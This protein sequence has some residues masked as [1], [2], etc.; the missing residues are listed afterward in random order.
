MRYEVNLA[1]QLAPKQA[2]GGIHP[3]PLEE[4]SL[5]KEALLGVS[6]L[7]LVNSSAL[8]LQLNK[9]MRSL[10]ASEPLLIINK[11][12]GYKIRYYLN[13]ASWSGTRYDVQGYFAFDPIPLSRSQEIIKQAQQ[14]V[15]VYQGS[16]RHLLKSLVLGRAREEGFEMNPI[17]QVKPSIPNYYTL[18]AT[19]MV[20]IT[21]RGA[22][23]QLTFVGPVQSSVDGNLLIPQNLQVSGPMVDKSS[24]FVLPQDYVPVIPGADDFMQYYERIYVHTDKPYYYPGEPLWFKGYINY[25]NPSWRD[26]L[27]RVAYVEI[28]SPDKKVLLTKTLR[29]ESGLFHGE[30][31][32][33]DSLASGSYFL[34]S[35]TQLGR[36]YGD[37]NLFMKSIPVMAMTERADH[38]QAVNASMEDPRLLIKSDKAVYKTREKI[39]L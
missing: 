21:Y 12:L 19:S 15:E 36:N 1:M 38:Q 23:S 29:I 4:T 6:D 26:S 32:L 31:L 35:Y 37:G 30:F 33:P 5:F 9:S 16:V 11:K 25:Y 24:P 28:I 39:N 8:S 7:N 3:A 18:E 20:T 14:R 13:R 22:A 27:S 10:L 34:R 2:G 17:V